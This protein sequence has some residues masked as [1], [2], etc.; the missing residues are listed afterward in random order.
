MILIIV[1][2]KFTVI[3]N[4][5]FLSW[6]LIVSHLQPDTNVSNIVISTM[7]QFYITIMWK[8]PNDQSRDLNANRWSPEAASID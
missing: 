8:S 2:I 7:I 1:S 3:L 4:I 5:A 6:L